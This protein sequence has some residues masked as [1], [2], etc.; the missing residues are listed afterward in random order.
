M[1]INELFGQLL[2]ANG[3]SGS[4][5]QPR[6]GGH[7]YFIFHGAEKLNRG[8]VVEIAMYYDELNI[9]ITKPIGIGH[10]ALRFIGYTLQIILAAILIVL[11]I[12]AAIEGA[13]IPISGAV[14]GGRRK[15]SKKRWNANSFKVHE[16]VQLVS[17][18]TTLNYRY[19]SGTAEKTVRDYFSFFEQNLLPVIKGEQWPTGLPKVDLFGY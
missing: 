6:M 2:V 7:Q 1:L 19:D 3:Y 18:G 16:V 10:K 14:G 9:V 17:A 15:P 4:Y 13:D 11:P 12:T 8:Y 5:K